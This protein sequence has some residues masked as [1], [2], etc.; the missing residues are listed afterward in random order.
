M[1]ATESEGSLGNAGV[2]V[3][4]SR[5]PANAQRGRS[6]KKRKVVQSQN[7]AS[8]LFVPLLDGKEDAGLVKLRY[9]TFQKLW[10][11]HEERIRNILQDIDSRIFEDLASFVNTAS[12]TAGRIPTALVTIGSN[13]S[14]LTR[15]LE[16]LASD[17]AKAEVV[18][19][20]SGDAPS[21]KTALK[22]IIRTAI[23]NAEGT[24][25]Y[26]KILNDR[27]GPRLLP[28][29]L[30]ILHEYVRK[31]DTGRLVIAFQDSEAFDQNLLNDLLSLISSWLDRIP[32]VLLFGIVTSSELFET[33]LPQSTASL[34]QGR[35]FEMHDVGGSIDRIYESFQTDP[36]VKLWL[37]HRPS[38]FLFQ[39]SRDYFQSPEGFACQVKYAYMSHFFANSLSVLLSDDISTASPSRAE[40]CQAVRNLPSFRCFCERLLEID[41][42]NEVH[43]LLEDDAHLFEET[44]RMLNSGQCQM[45]NL[46]QA[47]KAILILQ[48]H[49]KMSK[50]NNISTLSVR[51]LAGDLRDS[52]TVK[53]ILAE[54]KKLDSESLQ[55]LLSQIRKELGHCDI[56]QELQKELASFLKTEKVTGSL[57]SKHGNNSHYIMKTS[58]VGRANLGKASTGLSGKDLRYSDLLDRLHVTLEKFFTTMLINPQDL[59]LNEIFLF[60]LKNPL[61]DTFTPRVRFAIERALSTPFDYLMPMSDEVEGHLS[62]GQ[63]PTAI[64]YQLYLESG[65]LVNTYD[66]WKAFYTII[67]GEE[68]GDE[69]LTFTLFYQALSELKALGMVKSTRRRIDHISRSAWKGL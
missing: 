12:L 15:L 5:K 23:T 8:L 34:I 14:C 47:V 33:S 54:M 4:Q 50:T 22:N 37:G 18:V 24:E 58:T 29:D 44:I 52:A 41:R 35:C 2:Y 26:Q 55:L 17:K 62:A 56:F 31:K 25:Q 3:Y 51:A 9:A 67:G 60:D 11:K 19:L 42:H 6:S 65:S 59:F 1:D 66:L 40:L 30:N 61:K 49:L 7:D 32:F 45:G 13:V 68:T 43:D 36:D 16:R 20:D 57:R 53:E 48:T 39:K 63:P 38:S 64:L 27:A 28:Y 10:L 69:R 21:L 46:F